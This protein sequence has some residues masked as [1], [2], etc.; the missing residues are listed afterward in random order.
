MPVNRWLGLATARAAKQAW[1]ITGATPGSIW[2][3]RVG[4]RYYSFA[5][6]A[7]LEGVDQLELNRRAAAGLVQ[8]ITGNNL[9]GG[10]TDTV[11]TFDVSLYNGEWAV[12]ATGPSNGEPIDITISGSDPQQGQIS[13]IRLQK[14]A[15]AT[16]QRWFMKSPPTATGGNVVIRYEDDSR[17][18]AYD[19]AHNFIRA[20]INVIIAPKSCNVVGDA[21]SGYDIEI[22]NGDEIEGL[23]ASSVDMTGTAATLTEYTQI[24]G[25]GRQTFL[26]DALSG[27]SQETYQFQW[28]GQSSHLITGA[29]TNDTIRNALEGLLGADNVQVSMTATKSW[30]ITLVG[31]RV[32][33]PAE[34]LTLVKVTGDNVG[35][36]SNLQTSGVNL[37]NSRTIQTLT[38]VNMPTFGSGSFTLSYAP[39]TTAA[40]NFDAANATAANITAQLVAAGITEWECTQA[41]GGIESAFTMTLQ[42]V[43]S[44]PAAA[45]ALVADVSG[46]VGCASI[47]MEVTQDR[48]EE[49]QE[50]QQVAIAT[51][52]TGGTYTLTLDP[53]VSG[54]IAHDATP[55]SLQAILEAMPSIGAGNIEV[56]GSGGG[57]YICEFAGVASREL[58]S[59][60]PALLQMPSIAS[61]T[62]N[63]VTTPTGPNYWTNPAN[64][65]LGRIPENGDMVEFKNTSVSLL[66]DIELLGVNLLG[67]DIYQTFLGAIGLAP[68]RDDGNPETLPRFL[69]LQQLVTGAI[70]LRIG[71]GDD[72][73]GPSRV[74]LDTGNQEVVATIFRGQQ[75]SDQS[76]FA[77]ELQ[78]EFESI[79]I[80]EGHVLIGEERE[81]SVGA[82][83]V[84]GGTES[85]AT[86]ECGQKCSLDSL[87][88]IDG[89]TRLWK[90]P[91]SIQSQGGTV[92]VR[93][94]GD[95][96]L[97]HI[98]GTS[99]DYQAV[100]QIGNGGHVT[101]VNQSGTNEAIIVTENN[102][103]LATGN[104]VYIR[105]VT[106]HALDDGEYTIT[107]IDA[108]S[109]S[110]DGTTVAGGSQSQPVDS[111]EWGH[112]DS[113]IVGADSV[114]SF[115]TY[116]AARTV[117]GA[118]KL[119]EDAEIIDPFNTVAN[120]A[121]TPC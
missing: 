24:G 112:T 71:I 50:I 33:R 118:V 8:Q 39:K 31:E 12:V 34:S 98:V 55:A 74:N 13:V 75:S 41:S 3:M 103:N 76:P 95:L 92:V 32:G 5:L 120:L 73:Q 6:P 90:V 54:P 29:A 101:D 86:V 111:T 15:A 110:L 89:N 82:L 17:P 109:F 106:G 108:T 91:Q 87:E 62:I 25:V 102:H 30:E 100:G 115:A 94:I 19:A 1:Q 48:I 117:F 67:I 105:N 79:D 96:D 69:K 63:T 47:T 21:S 58:F 88:Q 78:G 2:Q 116:R 84:A 35:A 93:G 61:A 46:L 81:T 72:G 66:Y 99:M 59:G 83:Y 43:D 42:T 119:C 52:P 23:S 45:G 121:T 97:L 26:M 80:V 70:P 77:I 53:D 20:A 68:I 7:T 60:N 64:W 14:A 37:T 57:P 44:V 18:V 4:A 56:T 22:L 85:Q 113:I 49:R 28:D 114:L 10:A 36:R 16:N 38:F 51:D 107:V 65:S 40:I 27:D 104:K 11:T 9:G